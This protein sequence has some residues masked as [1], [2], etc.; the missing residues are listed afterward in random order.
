MCP[1]AA[2]NRV[3]TRLAQGYGIVLIRME[4]SVRQSVIRVSKFKG[5]FAGVVV[6]IRNVLNRVGDEQSVD[7]WC[8]QKGLGRR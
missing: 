3:E 5:P 4:V 8:V 1:V 2:R 7:M 6:K